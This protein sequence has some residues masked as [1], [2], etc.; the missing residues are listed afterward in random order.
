[1]MEQQNDI[2]KLVG[3]KTAN[4]AGINAK[5]HEKES[6]RKWHMACFTKNVLTQLF[7]QRFAENRYSWQDF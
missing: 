5:K 6:T 3:P 2:P 7:S 1:M 4:F